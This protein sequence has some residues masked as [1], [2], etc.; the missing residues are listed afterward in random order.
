MFSLKDNCSSF[1]SSDVRFITLKSASKEAKVLPFGPY[2]LKYLAIGDALW[3]RW[4]LNEWEL[5]N[6]GMTLRGG[7][8]SIQRKPCHHQV[9]LSPQVLHELVLDQT[10]VSVGIGWRL[11]VRIIA[12]FPR[13]VVN[14]LFSYFHF[15]LITEPYLFFP[16]LRYENNRISAFVLLS[17]IVTDSWDCTIDSE[18]GVRG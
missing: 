16:L 13:V 3:R 7:Y 8:W 5:T 6:G 10:Q 12:R 1:L 2:Y 11:P 14:L 17:H 9:T 15:V 4:Q 18:L